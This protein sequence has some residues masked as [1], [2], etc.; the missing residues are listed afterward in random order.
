MCVSACVYVMCMWNG[1]RLTFQNGNC[2]INS[3]ARNEKNW[4]KRKT[5]RIVPRYKRKIIIIETLIVCPVQSL[6]S[7][8]RY[9]YEDR[10]KRKKWAEF[11]ISFTAVQNALFLIWISSCKRKI[12][13]NDERWTLSFEI[14]EENEC[15]F[16]LRF[17]FVLYAGTMY[18]LSMWRYLHFW[19]LYFI[20]IVLSSKVMPRPRSSRRLTA[21][22]CGRA[23][24]IRV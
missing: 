6:Y 2:L 12:W 16:W 9:G 10:L 3:N 18:V 24:R 4:T 17:T 1:H 14:D 19:Y 20:S 13:T 21:N 15:N 7:M 22:W 8:Y 5:R 11:A 23:T